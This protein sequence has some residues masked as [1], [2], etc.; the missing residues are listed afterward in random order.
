M[1]KYGEGNLNTSGRAESLK[2]SDVEL[3]LSVREYTKD[4][5][6]N[7]VWKKTIDENG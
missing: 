5:N 7:Y 1:V 2:D 6:L 4:S 3:T